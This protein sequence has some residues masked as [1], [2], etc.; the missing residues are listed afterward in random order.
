[1]NFFQRKGGMEFLEGCL[2]TSTRTDSTVN[3]IKVPEVKKGIR[4]KRGEKLG[5]KDKVGGGW[6]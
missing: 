1:M 4:K 6:M 3:E 5:S 2:V